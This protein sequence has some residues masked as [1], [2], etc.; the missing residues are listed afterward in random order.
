MLQGGSK[1]PR[2]VWPLLLLKN[3]KIADCWTTAEAKE[4][5]IK[6]LESF[7]FEKKTDV[8]L[9][10]FKNNQILLNKISHKFLVT[11]KLFTR[12]NI[13]IK[14]LKKRAVPLTA[15]KVI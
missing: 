9:T 5:M 12:K 8:H 15:K 3:N 11:T 7:K 4:K 10:K 13:H 2:Y 1:G 14:I 6:Y